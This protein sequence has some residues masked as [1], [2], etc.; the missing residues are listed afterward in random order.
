MPLINY[1]CSCGEVYKKYIKSIKESTP[2]MPCKCGSQAKKSLGAVSSSYKITI[3][4]G[5]MAR[6]IEV[7][8]QIQEINDERS[9]KD[10]SED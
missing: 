10:Y 5:R 8:P 1:T 3:D 9:S 4:D 7:D 6:K 2:T